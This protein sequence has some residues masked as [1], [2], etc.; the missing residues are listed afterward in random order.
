MKKRKI[1]LLP[2]LLAL[3]LTGCDKGG[4]SQTSQGGGGTTSQTGGGTTSQGG[5]T[6]SSTDFFVDN[7]YTK[8]KGWPTALIGEFLSRNGITDTIPELSNVN[9]LYYATSEDPANYDY[10]SLAI[11]GSDRS[12][13]YKNKLTGAGY[14]IK[15]IDAAFAGVS[16]NETIGVT[17][18]YLKN[19]EGAPDAL[20]IL[21]VPNTPDS[22][23]LH[24][25]EEVRGWPT[26]VITSYLRR[27]GVAETLPALPNV[28][29]SYYA[30]MMSDGEEMLGVFV[31][32][33]DRS[34]EY[35]EVLTANGFMSTMGMYFNPEMTI[36]VFD[37]YL[38][39]SDYSII[40]GTLFIIM[41]SA[42]AE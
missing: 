8:T 6:S 26:E 10:F 29:K 33:G 5:E 34:E 12:S 23:G 38:A 24:L 4:E 13:E 36:I 35:G 37:N 2:M 28:T 25:F 1:L 14:T 31:P 27:V 20:Y 42:N 39:K 32:G 22:F 17:L 16:R 3:L 15:P 40:E 21:F 19:Y 41:A 7:G 9:T 30:S 18:G 11:P